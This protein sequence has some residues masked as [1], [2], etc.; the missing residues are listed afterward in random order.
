MSLYGRNEIVK[1]EGH[2]V[3][4]A[5]FPY[6]GDEYDFLRIDEIPKVILYPQ[7]VEMMNRFTCKKSEEE[8][9]FGCYYDGEVDPTHVLFSASMDNLKNI[10]AQMELQDFVDALCRS[11]YANE[12][13]DDTPE[14]KAVR[15]EAIDNIMYDRLCFSVFYP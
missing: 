5:S 10:V 7:R 8:V 9:T 12:S 11:V 15:K 2:D 6:E 3:I 13:I 14:I 1:L 4:Y